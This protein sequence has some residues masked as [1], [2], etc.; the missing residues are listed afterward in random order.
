[1]HE[2]QALQP[3]RPEGLQLRLWTVRAATVFGGRDPTA[4][5]TLSQESDS[6]TSVLIS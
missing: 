3:A 1:M 4:P 6:S 2:E 5:A